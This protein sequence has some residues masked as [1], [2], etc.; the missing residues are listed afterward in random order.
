MF[1]GKLSESILQRSD[2]KYWL[3]QY[4]DLAEQKLEYSW[5]MI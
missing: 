4:E 3:G 1:F 2:K 5:Q